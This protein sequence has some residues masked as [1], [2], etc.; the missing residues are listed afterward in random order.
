MKKRYLKELSTHELKQVLIINNKLY[1]EISDKIIDDWLELQ[2]EELKKI[3]ILNCV[4][5]YAHYNTFYLKLEKHKAVELFDNVA[6]DYLNKNCLKIY[7][8]AKI[9]LK[10][11]KNAQSDKIMFKNLEIIERKAMQLVEEIEKQLHEYE[12][13]PTFDDVVNFIEDNCFLMDELYIID[14]GTFV[15]CKDITIYYK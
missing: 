14:D 4:K 2:A 10:R 8:S 7:E 3:N 6:V 9:Y 1:N 5:R 15:C 12:K 13:K 11:F